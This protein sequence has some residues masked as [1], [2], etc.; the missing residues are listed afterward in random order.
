MIKR[1]IM[2]FPRFRN[3]QLINDIRSKYDPLAQHVKPHITLVFPFESDIE[4]NKLKEHI[5]TAMSGI[6][7]FHIILSGIT[8]VRSFGYY[9]FLNI[10]EGNAKI[11]EIHKKLY[12]GILKEIYPQWLK[13]KDFLPHMTVG[14][15][16]DLNNFKEAIE[17]TRNIETTFETTV[18][19]IS[20]EIIDENEDSFIEL[21]ITLRG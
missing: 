14:A 4:T 21:N 11:I 18:N 7:P 15:F 8:P 17:Q 16:T 13:D 19:T 3:I 6:K 12:N 1:C 9:L 20:V 5:E 10:K 2:I